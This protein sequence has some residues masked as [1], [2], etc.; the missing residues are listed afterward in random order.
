MYKTTACLAF[1]LLTVCGGA[2]ADDALLGSTVDGRKVVLYNDGTWEFKKKNNDV[3]LREGVSLMDFE[4]ENIPPDFSSAHPVKRVKLVLHV[5]NVGNRSVKCWKG[6]LVIKD[7][8]TTVVTTRQSGAIVP[9]PTRARADRAGASIG[10]DE[11]RA[12][13]RSCSPDVPP[14]RRGAADQRPSFW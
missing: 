4:K 5:K 6:T 13:R 10:R 8:Q 9:S 7:A 3:T 1:I 14:R 11:G 12:L 2:F